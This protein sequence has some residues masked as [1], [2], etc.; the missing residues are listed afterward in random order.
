MVTARTLTAFGLGQ[1]THKAPGSDYPCIHLWGSGPARWGLRMKLAGML[2]LLAG[3][4]IVV[5]SVA[6]FPLPM[7]RILFVF[8]GLGVQGLGLLLAFRSGRL[9]EGVK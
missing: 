3:W 9:A 5:S 8:A 4:G 6:L 1:K 7:T 2:L